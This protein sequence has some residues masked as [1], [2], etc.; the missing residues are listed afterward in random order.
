MGSIFLS[1]VVVS[2]LLIWSLNETNR[3]RETTEKGIELIAEAR[4]MHTLMVAL[5]FDIFTP[6]TYQLLKDVIHT[7][8]YNTT[9]RTFKE[10]AVH[11]KDSFSSF[12]ELDRVKRMRRAGQLKDE[13]DVALRMSDKTF[14]EIS[15]FL[16]NLDILEEKGLLGEEKIYEMIQTG[17]DGFLLQFFDEVR[18]SSYYLTN[19]FESFL[20]HFISTLRREFVS[21]QRRIF[22]VFW[23]ITGCLGVFSFLLSFT[24]ARGIANKI[25]AVESTIRKVS[26][27]NL[28]A[29]MNLKSR[30]E[31]GILSDNFNILI[32]DLKG[33][34]NSVHNLTRDVGGVISETIQ[35]KTI[36]TVI[37]DSVVKDM[38][39]DSA[40]VLMQET[41]GG[42]LEIKS[43]AG[44]PLL[45]DES[46]G[47]EL[48]QVIAE[49]QTKFVRAQEDGT[50]MRGS[51]IALPLMVRGKHLGV[52]L[53]VRGPGKKGLTDLDF[54]NL[55][56]FAEYAALL[57][58]N[59]YKYSE[60]LEKREAEFQ[61]LQS[62]IQ[63]HFLYNV[64]GLLIGL[65]RS[66]DGKSLERAVLCLRGMLRYI[67]DEKNW[68]TVREEME[69][70]RDYCD[71]Q[72]LRFRNRLFFSLSLQEQAADFRIPKL[73]LQPLVE[74]AVIHGIEPKGGEGN[75]TVSAEVSRDNGSRII[76]LSVADD[77]VGFNPGEIDR[78][79]H[80]GLYNVR[81]RLHCAF[82]SARFDI[83][84]SPGSGTRLRLTI[85][86]KESRV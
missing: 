38:K 77:G 27:G 9:L 73:L 71:L 56:T 86:E 54:T 63:P 1:L 14:G 80:I 12:M 57:L 40:V 35:L 81:E 46:M 75:L 41:D 39:A 29:R 82:S 84:S 30:D 21:M 68:V 79:R 24:F 13:Y 61:A 48:K 70:I 23:S 25:N 20:D 60:L 55:N 50:N 58:D 67:L 65:N 59:F 78:G 62:Q 18:S 28:N 72:K 69:F 33:N 15:R 51:H 11:F 64:L 8:R 6:Q 34:I 85:I 5:M 36:L 17:Q 52:L 76:S 2:S 31:F 74:N 45:I 53:I 3:L 42:S 83:R 37:A 26:E 44:E 32:E 10:T 43:S 7:S 49:G 19:S 22:I 66:G 47:E 16:G 4:N